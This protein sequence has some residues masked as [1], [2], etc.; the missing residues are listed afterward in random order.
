[1]T[2]PHEISGCYGD[3]VTIGCGATEKI[4]ILGDF[5]GLSPPDSES[6]VCAYSEHDICVVPSQSQSSGVK[7]VPVTI[8]FPSPK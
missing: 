5:Y 2:T 4:N 3:M 1:M 7:Q 8:T 6:R